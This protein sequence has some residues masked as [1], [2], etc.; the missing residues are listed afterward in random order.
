MSV[1]YAIIS[2][3]KGPRTVS[4]TIHPHFERMWLLSY[5]ETIAY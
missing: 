5:L 2:M 3:T 1:I 4:Y